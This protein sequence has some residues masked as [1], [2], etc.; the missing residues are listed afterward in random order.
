MKLYD[1]LNG[2]QNITLCATLSLKAINYFAL[3]ILGH[4]RFGPCPGYKNFGHKKILIRNFGEQN[5]L[6]FIVKFGLKT[7]A[8]K[9]MLQTFLR[10]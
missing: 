7:L 9:I 1:G 8:D 6:R 5:S 3:V 10:T 2:L 4:K